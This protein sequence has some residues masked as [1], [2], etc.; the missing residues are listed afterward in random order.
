MGAR[1]HSACLFCAG[2]LLLVFLHR[3]LLGSALLISGLLLFVAAQ[4][5]PPLSHA[6]ESL[7][8]KA[9]SLAAS[10]AGWILLAPF[11]VIFFSAGRAVLLVN[12]KDPLRLQFPSDEV[13][14]WLPVSGGQEKETYKRPY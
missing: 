7:N 13:T 9:S 12:R 10:A 11:Y 14:Y 2:V 6:I 1:I 8:R 5:Y 4:F 3:R